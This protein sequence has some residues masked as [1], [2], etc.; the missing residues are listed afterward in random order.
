M[1]LLVLSG[2]SAVFGPMP[3]MWGLS[4]VSRDETGHRGEVPESTRLAAED[5]D[6]DHLVKVFPGVSSRLFPVPWKP[7]PGPSPRP[8][9]GGTTLAGGS[10]HITGNFCEEGSCLLSTSSPVRTL[11]EALGHGPTPFQVVGVK[12]FLDLH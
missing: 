6:L 11:S 9:G 1:T 10:P 8:R 12:Q 7:G 4:G 2:S 5:A 3:L